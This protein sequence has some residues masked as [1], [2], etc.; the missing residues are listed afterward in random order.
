MHAFQSCATAC[1]MRTHFAL[2]TLMYGKS[3]SMNISDQTALKT[4]YPLGGAANRA[5][6]L[7]RQFLRLSPTTL[8]PEYQTSLLYS[9]HSHLEPSSALE[10]VAWSMGLK[11]ALGD[12]RTSSLGG[13]SD[14][15]A[16]HCFDCSPWLSAVM[17]ALSDFSTAWRSTQV[18]VANVLDLHDSVSSH[19]ASG[20]A[21]TTRRSLGWY[22]LLLEHSTDCRYLYLSVPL[23]GDGSLCDLSSQG[24]RKRFPSADQYVHYRLSTSRSEAIGTAWSYKRMLKNLSQQLQKKSSWMSTSVTQ[25]PLELTP[26]SQELCS[27]LDII[28]KAWFR[29]S[30][31][32]SRDNS[33]SLQSYLVTVENSCSESDLPSDGLVILPDL[34][35]AELPLE[36]LLM[37]TVLEQITCSVSLHGSPDALSTD[38]GH[39]AK[40]TVRSASV[41]KTGSHIPFI[42][43]AREF[44]LMYLHSRLS[45]DTTSR[46]ELS[47][48]NAFKDTARKTDTHR[49]QSS[50]IHPIIRGHMERSATSNAP[51]KNRVS[52]R[53]K[54]LPGS[55][56][57]NSA[58]MC[59]LVDPH[60]DT[61]SI[62]D[63]HPND[64]TTFELGK[65]KLPN[66]T[67]K[68]GGATSSHLPVSFDSHLKIL[69]DRETTEYRE[70]TSHWIRLIG[71]RPEGYIPSAGELN[72]LLSQ[73]S[74]G[75][76][77]YSTVGLG[78]IVPP[79]MLLNISLSN[80]YFV[81]LFDLVHTPSSVQRLGRSTSKKTILQRETENS[82][83]MSVILTLSG[84]RS[85]IL[86]QHHT[87]LMDLQ[88]RFEHFLEAALGARLSVGQSAFHA[89]LKRLRSELSSALA[90]SSTIGSQLPEASTAPVYPE[91]TLNRTEESALALNDIEHILM[92]CFCMAIY[93]L[94]NIVFS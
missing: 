2:T 11:A 78:D 81:G 13:L 86:S 36:C 90:M 60:G 45:S 72:V 82:L 68:A 44:S 9:L 1:R 23:L 50:R 56:Q 32:A 63:E 58:T 21:S 7:L 93:G 75:F 42:W 29:A 15:S 14:G 3:E 35:L 12:R 24:S 62:E 55:F 26:K 8:F 43:I 48:E 76:L 85:V 40:K 34:W 18:P 20:S 41:S 33:P 65:K 71:N 79:P 53:G 27:L 4:G 47:V 94:P 37:H 84:C 61:L 30:T 17:S 89:Q 10:C 57:I 28:A 59:L 51:R 39:T 22:F 54:N 25:I 91:G 52:L 64:P 73:L 38:S 77:A 80:C 88:L 46:T 31:T 66:A 5:E 70:L 74:S 67:I 6:A 87:T 16:D 83:S 69:L 49:S 19:L 92:K